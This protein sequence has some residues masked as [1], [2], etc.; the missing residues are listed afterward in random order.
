MMR[1]KCEHIPI[2]EYKSYL[3]YL[4]SKINVKFINN[5]KY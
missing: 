3:H 1:N 5:G 2:D 4:M